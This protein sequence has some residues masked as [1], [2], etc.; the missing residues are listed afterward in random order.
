MPLSFDMTLGN[1]FLGGVRPR[2]RSWICEG[3]FYKNLQFKSDATEPV[4]NLILRRL[5]QESHE[6]KV[7]LDCTV[8]C[9]KQSVLSCFCFCKVSDSFRTKKAERRGLS[10]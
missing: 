10:A 2:N 7:T 8:T 5:R 1:I 4:C 3:C 9:H 6:V